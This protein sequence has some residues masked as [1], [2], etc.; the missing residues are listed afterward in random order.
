MPVLSCSKMT[1]QRGQ[2][3]GLRLR[4]P[5]A[6][7]KRVLRSEVAKVR[8]TLPESGGRDAQV[9]TATRE[10]ATQKPPAQPGAGRL[11]VRSMASVRCA[12]LCINGSLKM[13]NLTLGYGSSAQ[14]G[15]CPGRVR[16]DT[17]LPR[18]PSGQR[19]AEPARPPARP[20]GGAL[21][22]SPPA[23]PRGELPSR[24]GARAGSGGGLG[25]PRARHH[26]PVRRQTLLGS[27][28]GAAP[29]RFEAVASFGT[30]LGVL[31]SPL[32]SRISPA[33]SASARCNPPSPL[34]R[35]ASSTAPSP[36]S[37]ANAVLQPGG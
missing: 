37:G 21:A 25:G 19:G 33:L 4:G 14:P 18:A 13:S 23:P 8:E 7:V 29:R 31:I 17:C 10:R 24:G 1:P 20:R 34:P 16:R 5:L 12:G 32:L 15:P 2:V 11:P 26:C 3:R 22:P 28:P 27:A 35:E 6:G 36:R 30:S 9:T